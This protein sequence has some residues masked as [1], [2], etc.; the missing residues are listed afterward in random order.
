MNLRSFSVRM[1]L[2]G[3]FGLLTLGFS[4]VAAGLIW[5]GNIASQKTAQVLSSNQQERDIALQWLSAIHQN[6]IRTQ[7]ALSSNDSDLRKALGRDMQA[8]SAQID[9][10][11]KALLPYLASSPEKEAY[12]QASSLRTIY[13][14]A[15]KAAL[16]EQQAAGAT[17]GSQLFDTQVA[18]AANAYLAAVDNVVASAQQAANALARDSQY[19]AEQERELV[20]GA[21]LAC[22]LL[23]GL[24]AWRIGRSITVPLEQALSLVSQLAR[25]DLRLRTSDENGDE[26]GLLITQIHATAQSM[27]SVL[28]EIQQVS[29][30]VL[31]ATSE[32]AAGNLDLSARTESQ[33][34]SLQE[35]A[36]AVEELSATVANNAQ[37]SQ[38]A[39]NETQQASVVT[40]NAE[41]TM[42]D[43]QHA[44]QRIHDAS[45]KVSDI[46]A[47]IDTI[48]FQTNILALNAA[49]EAAR[50]G[51][52][53]RGFA[54]VATEVRALAQR[55]ANSAREIKEVVGQT[56][57]EIEAGVAKTQGA[58]S[59]VQR[60][61]ERVDKVQSLMGDISAASQQQAAGLHQVN[62]AIAALDAT[63]QQ[64]S[65]LVEEAAAAAQ[66]L[67]DQAQHLGTLTARF[68][69]LAL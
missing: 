50:A 36:A 4:G 39:V 67:R 64:N 26:L 19:Q 35:S 25:G 10:T 12:A 65:A 59:A 40:A 54:V 34:S 20:V 58:T 57:M 47:L 32:I 13:T 42:H 61:R 23:A 60:A 17:Q 22:A 8:T 52:E 30:S 29:D 16:A 28:G 53:G 41:T 66:S 21:V 9:T 11:Q 1:R 27:G 69:V 62:G 51:P 2:A 37:A 63:T 46:S 5:Q 55:T 33:A 49:V 7:V 31:T 38:L 18:Q 68:Q 45:T 3:A 43:I 14:T 15:R 44:M 6:A 48:A 24:L 56:L